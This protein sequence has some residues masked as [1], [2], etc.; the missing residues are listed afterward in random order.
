MVE[1]K[2]IP[3]TLD[4]SIPYKIYIPDN[5]NSNTPIIFY[6]HGYG[7]FDNDYMALDKLLSNEGSNAIV[8]GYYNQRASYQNN[9]DGMKIL[10]YISSEYKVPATN[11]KVVGFS[12]GLEPALRNMGR[13]IQQNPNMEPQSI[14]LVDGSWGN[15]SNVM[16]DDELLNAFS[17]NNTLIFS[18][19]QPNITISDSYY[20]NWVTKY[21]INVL[22][23]TDNTCLYKGY[24]SHENVNFNYADN[25]LLSF[26]AGVGKFPSSD[27]YTVEM[28]NGISWVP[29]N[30][31]GMTLSQV[32]EFVG[33]DTYDYKINFLLNLN[34]VDVVSTSVTSDSVVLGS[35]INEVINKIKL[36]NFVQN[37]VNF[38]GDFGGSTTSVPMQ[39][40]GVA[41][42]FFYSNA[43]FLMGLANDMSAIAQIGASIDEINNHLAILAGELNPSGVPI[44]NPSD[45]PPEEPAKPDEEPTELKEEP[46]ELKEEPAEPKGEPA[47]PK[48]EPAKPDD[49]FVTEE[50]G[51]LEEE[52][53]DD[54]VITEEN[55]ETSDDE[56]MEPNSKP[57]NNGDGD[58]PNSTPNPTPNSNPNPN[59][60]PNSNPNPAPNPKQPP[61]NNFDGGNP[62]IGD[63]II[64]NNPLGEFPEYSEVYS[65]DNMIVYNFNDEYKI[66]IHTDGDKIIGIEHYYDFGSE[67]NADNALNNLMTQ[68]SN[69]ENFENIIQNDRY[70]KVIFDEDMY[71]NMSISDIRK[72]YS[73]LTEIVKI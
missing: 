72:Q 58:V 19:N 64:Y 61:L 6:E 48:E 4:G 62:G 35:C 71:E 53:G 51:I 14:F 40:P 70:V 30:I 38:A 60:T 73:N 66:V 45:T 8:V 33:I 7:G 23:L 50:G 57:E 18:I 9:M 56:K 21:G 20:E 29:V 68:Y 59:P 3:M 25:D 65:N 63:D 36:S 15:Y 28:F 41:S 43:T 46:A 67:F 1:R 16:V 54:E 11:F 2:M 17:K 47:E 49:K 39:I 32:Y 34:Q 22:R 31:E 42:S 5:V 26:H 55:A 13:V 27:I 52:T 12:W 10:N 44:K 37:N 69:N 24:S